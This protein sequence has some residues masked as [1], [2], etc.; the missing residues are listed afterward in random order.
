[1]EIDAECFNDVVNRFIRIKSNGLT[2]Q[3]VVVSF[4]VYLLSVPHPLD[5]A[6]ST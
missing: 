5:A 4:V 2:V 6:Q 3:F 1:M